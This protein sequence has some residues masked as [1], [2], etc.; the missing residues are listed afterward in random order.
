MKYR[1][2]RIS[3][4]NAA[5]WLYTCL[6]VLKKSLSDLAGCYTH[7]L[8]LFPYVRLWFSSMKQGV[9]KSIKVPF[10][11]NWWS[12]GRC[13]L[14]F[15]RI[16]LFKWSLIWKWKVA[17]VFDCVCTQLCSFIHPEY[18]YNNSQ[19]PPLQIWWNL[20]ASVRSKSNQRRSQANPQSS[21]CLTQTSLYQTPQSYHDAIVYRYMYE[22]V[23]VNIPGVFVICDRE[24]SNM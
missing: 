8:L 16:Y 2:A 7:E 3:A 22:H 12:D 14:L 17:G 11:R 9:D 15:H 21:N 10:R 18:V 1:G 23:A 6:F 19:T 13:L 4:K 5:E 20:M 24:W